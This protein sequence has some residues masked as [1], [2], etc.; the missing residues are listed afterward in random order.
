MLL[1]CNHPSNKKLNKDL[2]NNVNFSGK[3]FHRFGWLKDEEIGKLSHEFNWLVNWYNE[4]ED[5]AP[6]ILH[7]TEGG[8]WLD[9]YNKEQYA[10]IW[11]N[12][13]DLYSKDK[14]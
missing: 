3:F 5:G 2:I 8:P 1:N 9:K 11:F 7:F 14:K 6:K 12:E 13:L 10:D 4:P